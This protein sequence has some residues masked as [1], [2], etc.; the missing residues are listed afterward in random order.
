MGSGSVWFFMVVLTG[1]F[2]QIGLL[3]LP[4]R[5][6]GESLG[7]VLSS[8]WIS[9]DVFSEGSPQALFTV[10]RLVADLRRLGGLLCWSG[11]CKDASLSERGG[12]TGGLE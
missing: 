5:V 8:Q 7:R 3:I 6:V 4:L 12:F 10:G 9:E 1:G 11:L 2:S